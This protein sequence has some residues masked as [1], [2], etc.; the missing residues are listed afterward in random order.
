MGSR[1]AILF[2]V[3]LLLAPAVRAGDAARVVDIDNAELQTMIERGVTVVDV[4]TAGEWRQT[5][6]IAGAERITAFDARGRFVPGFPAALA[7]AVGRSGDLVLICWQGGR[8]TV[9]SR[10][11]TEQAGYAR[12]FN[13]VGGMRSWLAEGRPVTPCPSC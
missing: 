10:A 8:S 4:R 7:T 2:A 13:A 1:F 3:V 5:G 6:V 9:L 11:L 12:V